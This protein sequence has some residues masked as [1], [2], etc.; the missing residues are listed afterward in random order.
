MLL[1]KEEWIQ[2][3]KGSDWTTRQIRPR[4]YLTEPI[5]GYSITADMN[6]TQYPLGP[7]GNPDTKPLPSVWGPWQTIG[8]GLAIGA[9]YFF[10]QSSV[11]IVFILGEF[12]SNP[13][14]DLTT[15]LHLSDNGLLV[16]VATLFSALAGSGAI[17][18]VIRLLRVTGVAEYLGLKPLSKRAVLMVMAIP[19][20]LIAISELLSS[21]VVKSPNPQFMIDI[22]LTSGWTPLLWIAIV[23]FA[24]AF[25]EAFFRGF[26]LTG[27]ERSWMGGPGAVCLT[28]L[29]WA[30]LHIQYDIYGMATVLVLGIVL[31][32]VRLKTRSLWSSLLIHSF[33]NFVALLGTALYVNGVLT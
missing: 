15:L 3:E 1:R 20:V 6:D 19:V 26:L 4:R 21:Q 24:P 16:S 5:S 14:F 32:I 17:V 2:T 31:G 13:A 30:V 11:A 12:F 9:V 27:L 7:P 10:A 23:I 25:E 29:T 28:A 22:Y 33:W 18:L 8:F